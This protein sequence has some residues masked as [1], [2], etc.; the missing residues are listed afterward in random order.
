M[1]H[2]FINGE[3]K[4][5]PFDNWVV[6]FPRTSFPYPRDGISFGEVIEGEGKF[7]E[8]V[9]PTPRPEFDPMTHRAVLGQPVQLEDGT[10]E[11]TWTLE[12]LPPP[13]EPEP[14]FNRYTGND[15]LDLFTKEEQ[16]AVVTA[17]LTD[18]QV[19]LTYDR[20]LGANFITYENPEMEMGLSLLVAK[21]LI[22]PERKEAI[23]L[24]M[25]T[26][27]AVNPV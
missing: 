24:K 3:D 22:T 5:Y 10:W 26:P 7:V 16:L 25:T 4:V 11:D 21:E 13:P 18:P 6:E 2:I 20:L 12:E 17:T 9:K 15:K 27:L 23:V 19:K 8:W 1:A 14:H